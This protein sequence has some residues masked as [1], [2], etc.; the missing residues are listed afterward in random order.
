MLRHVVFIHAARRG[1]V[2][3]VLFF[4][5][6]RRACRV[7]FVLPLFFSTGALFRFFPTGRVPVLLCSRDGTERHDCRLFGRD[8]ARH[9]H[10]SHMAQGAE[11]KFTADSHLGFVPADQQPW[12]PQRVR[13][14]RSASVERAETR[15]PVCLFLNLSAGTKARKQRMRKVA[16]RSFSE[17]C[18]SGCW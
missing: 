2:R 15:N 16:K 10:R 14:L 18:I 1:Q 13:G 5:H 17:F 4:L 3:F 9:G 11:T 7:V 12:L 6:R 8:R